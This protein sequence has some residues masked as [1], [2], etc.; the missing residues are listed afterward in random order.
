MEQ[1]ASDINPIAVVANGVKSVGH[2]LSV[3]VRNACKSE[4]NFRGC[5]IFGFQT[6]ETHESDSESMTACCGD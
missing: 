4:C 6:Y 2:D 5:W 3:Y 1:V